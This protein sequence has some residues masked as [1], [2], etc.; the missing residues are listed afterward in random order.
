MGRFEL[1]AS[2]YKQALEKQ[3]RDW[4]L[5]N[6]ISMFLTFNLR[7]PKRGVDMA[8]VALSLNP[9]CSVEVGRTIPRTGP[10][11]RPVQSRRNPASVDG[12]VTH[13]TPACSSSDSRAA[14][15]GGTSGGTT[16]SCR[17]RPVGRT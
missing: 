13:G 2:F 7:H 11:Q 14:G 12:V 4:V 10:S 5:L 1:A 8:K 17:N 16:P 6:E 9:T 3:P 15:S